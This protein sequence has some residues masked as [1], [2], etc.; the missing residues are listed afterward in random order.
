MDVKKQMVMTTC[1]LCGEQKPFSEMQY[2]THKQTYNDGSIGFKLCK[3]CYNK[4]I[5]IDLKTV[6]RAAHTINAA[7]AGEQEE[8]DTISN[9]TDPNG[10]RWTW[11]NKNLHIQN[12]WYQIVENLQ[13][14]EMRP[15]NVLYPVGAWKELE[16]TNGKDIR[17]V[18]VEKNN[19]NF[20]EGKFLTKWVAIDPFPEQFTI[21]DVMT[22]EVNDLYWEIP[23]TVR[24]AINIAVRNVSGDKEYIWVPTI[25]EYELLKK[26]KPEI[27]ETALADI[28]VSLGNGTFLIMDET[29]IDLTAK[30]KGKM[31]NQKANVLIGFCI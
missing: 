24:T 31:K 12:P 30:N 10:R 13:G 26:A 19:P 2:F 25:K 9:I 4:S 21:N 8:Q 3:E 1:N 14:C 17:M 20:T 27:K 6:I 16:F 29:D 15:E 28:W 11:W 18:L 23:R 7:A 22:G 5:S